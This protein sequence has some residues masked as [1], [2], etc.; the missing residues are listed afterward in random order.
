MKIQQYNE[1]E[2]NFLTGLAS[3]ARRALG[4]AGI[5]RLEQ[6]TKFRAAEVKQWPGIGPHAFNQLRLALAARGLSF[7]K[8]E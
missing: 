4:A 1:Q 3:P 6:L 8:E 5:Q 2:T 7:A